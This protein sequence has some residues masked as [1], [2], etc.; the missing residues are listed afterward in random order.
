MI[1][2]TDS[3]TENNDL[4]IS[5]YHCYCDSNY[6]SYANNKWYDVSDT[7]TYS[8]DDGYDN[9]ERLL[10]ITTEYW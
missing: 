3:Y 9:D 5:D 1:S 4:T 10:V 2:I 7:D 8:D 6:I